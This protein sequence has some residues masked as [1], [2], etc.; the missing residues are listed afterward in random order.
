MISSIFIKMQFLK[1][2]PALSKKK[3]KGQEVHNKKWLSHFKQPIIM[4]SSEDKKTQA[5]L[6][7]LGNNNEKLTWVSAD[8]ISL[9][10]YNGVLISSRGFA[11]DLM[12]LNHP[13]IEKPFEKIGKE[14]QKTYRYING[15][16]D[17]NDIEFTCQ[18]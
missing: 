7:L 15:E 10:F 17:Y 12:A 16:N 14:Y 13:F 9:S 4:I 3:P 6:V 1:K 18:M 2:E 5:T 11:Q 8:G